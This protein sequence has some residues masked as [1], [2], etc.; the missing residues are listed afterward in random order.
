MLSSWLMDNDFDDEYDSLITRFNKFLKTKCA[1]R[2]RILIEDY[3]HL[4]YLK[5][6]N[7]S[8]VYP[9]IQ[10]DEYWNNECQNAGKPS[11]LLSITEHM[12]SRWWA[13]TEHVL[14]I[15]W[16]CAKHVQRIPLESA[17]IV[18]DIFLAYA[19]HI[20]IICQTCF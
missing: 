9:S 6:R 3:S 4:P 15:C 8:A 18:P 19:S 12:M 17:K 5:F 11:T 16:E 10:N 7:M 13:F 20:Y 2:V 14:S 1:K